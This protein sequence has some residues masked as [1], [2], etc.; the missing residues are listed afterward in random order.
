MWVLTFLV[1]AALGS[2]VGVVA[3]DPLREGR[4]FLGGLR[5][6]SKVEAQQGLLEQAKVIT[7][8]SGEELE[9][10]FSI[11]NEGWLGITITEIPFASSVGL[12]EVK[13]IRRGVRDRCCIETEPFAPFSLG[14][15]EERFIQLRGVLKGCGDLSPGTST[16]WDSYTVR[17]RILGI[18]R[19]T[20]VSVR[21]TVIIEIPHGYRCTEPPRNPTS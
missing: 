3:Y 16:G 19:T 2:G 9:I 13:E 7:Y 20:E 17:Y 6:P 21:S 5:G 1:L 4:F 11:R 14:R 12:F 18:T 15:H 10:E 8:A